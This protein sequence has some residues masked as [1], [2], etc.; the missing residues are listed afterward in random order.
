M[1]ATFRR[2]GPSCEPRSETSFR[3]VEVRDSPGFF[4]IETA[5]SNSP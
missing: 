3:S 1:S 5:P 4:S 2:T